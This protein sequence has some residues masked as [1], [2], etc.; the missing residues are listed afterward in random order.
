MSA[1]TTPFLQVTVQERTW[2]NGDTFVLTCSKPA[3]FTFLAGQHVLLLHGGEEREY[4][5][6]SPPEAPILRFLIKRVA[7]GRLS[8]ALAEM[9]MGTVLSMGQA[10]GYLTY[11]STQRPA[12][13]VATGVGIAPFEAMAANGVTGFTLIQGARILSGLFF[14]E[15]LAA[16]ASRYIPCLT[17]APDEVDLPDL[18]RGHVTGYVERHLQPGSYDFYLCGSRA[19]I[20]DMTLLL[21]RHCPTARVFSEAYT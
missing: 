19:M 20:T 9:K 1:S 11:R 18:F 16:V 17:E 6:L 3:G 4:T 12:V 13:F 15:H 10:K 8:T 2:L 14:R 21:D 7:A 5:L